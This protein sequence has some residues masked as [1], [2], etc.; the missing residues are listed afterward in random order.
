M[1]D[2]DVDPVFAMK[3]LEDWD[4]GGGYGGDKY[5]W[6]LCEA[7]LGSVWCVK[8]PAWCVRKPMIESAERPIDPVR[9][10]LTLQQRG[11]VDKVRRFAVAR[12]G[13]EGWFWDGCA[14]KGVWGAI[15][16]AGPL[17]PGLGSMS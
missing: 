16:R 9:T 7:C 2:R 5:P 14:A 8:K 13:G 17:W 1:V 12:G 15:P 10:C 4:L 3:S 6:A 11:A